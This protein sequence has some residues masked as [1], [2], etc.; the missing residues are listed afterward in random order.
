MERTLVNRIVKFYQAWPE[1]LPDGQDGRLLSW[2]HYKA[3]LAIEDKAE[4]EFYL[5]EEANFLN[6]ELLDNSL[7]ELI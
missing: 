5:A 3:L 4:R 6:Q 1:K 7:A 2:S